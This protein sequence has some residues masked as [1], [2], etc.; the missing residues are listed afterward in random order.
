M[1]EGRLVQDDRDA[2]LVRMTDDVAALVLEDNRLQALAL[3]IAEKGGAGAVPSLVRIMETFEGS[4]RLDRKVEGLAAN[5]E[6]M[7]RAQEGRGLT[8]P[9]LAILLS[10]AKLALQ[11]AIAASELPEIGRAGCRESRC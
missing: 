1:I 9:E 11:D 4:G 2:L 5:D 6:L 8:R 3:S 7:R 10:T